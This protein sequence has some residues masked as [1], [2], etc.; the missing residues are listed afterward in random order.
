M[1]KAKGG[2]YAVAAGHKPGIY[3]TWE[4]CKRQVNGYKGAKYKK[5]SC[6]EEA[7]AFCSVA[8][9]IHEANLFAHKPWE[10]AY[11]DSIHNAPY[12]LPK[13]S[14]LN[15]APSW[16]APSSSRPAPSRSRAPH[17]NSRPYRPRSTILLNPEAVP[18]QPRSQLEPAAAPIYYN[19]DDDQSSDDVESCDEGF[20]PG[21]VDGRAPSPLR[22]PSGKRK[23]SDDVIA[24]IGALVKQDEDVMRKRRRVSEMRVVY[25]DGSC[26]GNGKTKGRAGAGVWWG[27]GDSNNLSERLYGVQTNNRAELWAAIRALQQST[28]WGL[29]EVE[30]RTDSK[31]TIQGI[32]SWIV[33]WKRNGWRTGS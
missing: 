23:L 29:P 1:G 8:P 15:D 24:D 2:Y 16:A 30:V 9:A 3:T 5:F 31:Y 7:Q 10:A 12:H 19:S 27:E 25:T 22:S 21:R 28:E 14:P 20:S 17:P 6:M 33:K 11:H 32:T 26:L 18:F 13:D 4:D